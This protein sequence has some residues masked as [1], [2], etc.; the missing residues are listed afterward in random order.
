MLRNRTLSAFTLSELLIAISVVGIIAAMSIPTAVSN[1]HKRT[2]TS[3]LKSIVSSFQQI[4]NNQMIVKHTRDLKYT[5]FADSSKLLSDKN[6]AIAQYCNSDCW[7]TVEK[8][9]SKTVSHKTI[10]GN[11]VTHLSGGKTVRLKNG[12]IMTYKIGGGTGIAGT[13]EKTYA[14]V[15]VDVNGT[16]KPNIAGRDYF[17][18]YVSDKGRIFG[19]TSPG[20]GTKESCK[21]SAYDCFDYLSNSNWV[22]DY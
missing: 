13:K 20:T 14:I 12:A 18:F 1:L 9:V 3:E 6:F 17:L 2:M 10:S 4:S 22:M 21:S 8:G 15:E 7:K 16:D 11:A 19:L 5:D